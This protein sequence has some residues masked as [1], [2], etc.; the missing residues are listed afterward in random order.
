[1][2]VQQSGLRFPPIKPDSA[3]SVMSLKRGTDMRGCGLRREVEV[4]QRWKR[5]PAAEAKSGV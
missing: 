5:S 1:M 4:G 2:E 3:R